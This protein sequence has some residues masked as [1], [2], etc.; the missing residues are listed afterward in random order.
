MASEELHLLGFDAGQTLFLSCDSVAS[1]AI[2]C[3]P[4][5]LASNPVSPLFWKL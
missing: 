5:L 4:P 2:P 3:C 1:I